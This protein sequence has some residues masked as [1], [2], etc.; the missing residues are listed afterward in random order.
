M[1]LLAL[2]Q[3]L[4]Q[5]PL[6]AAPLPDWLP[7]LLTRLLRRLAGRDCAL[8]ARLEDWQ[9]RDLNLTRP[10]PGP[11]FSLTPWIP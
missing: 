11:G 5:R 8:P 1:T 4:P 2:F 3:P 9:L 7:L 6:P 10:H